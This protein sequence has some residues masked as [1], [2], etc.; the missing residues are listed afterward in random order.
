MQG[1]LDLAADRLLI[2]I[3]VNRADVHDIGLMAVF[4]AGLFINVQRAFQNFPWQ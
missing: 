4:G 3:D 1:L 2:F